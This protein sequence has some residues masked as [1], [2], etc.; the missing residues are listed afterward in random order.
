MFNNSRL[1]LAQTAI[2]GTRLKGLLSED[3]VSHKGTEKKKIMDIINEVLKDERFENFIKHSDKLKYK[4]L[5]DEKLDTVRDIAK[6][7][8]I[9]DTKEGVREAARELYDA[10]VLVYGATA[11]RPDKDKIELDFI[12]YEI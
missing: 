6:S 7:W 9:P 12:L 2:H 8:Y 11:I 4:K 5:L 1:G 10:C 3:L